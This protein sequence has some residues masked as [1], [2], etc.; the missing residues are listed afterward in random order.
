MDGLGDVY[1]IY[2]MSIGLS[3]KLNADFCLKMKQTSG[4]KLPTCGFS[5]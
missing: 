4:L 1:Q 3:K 2:L 5:Q